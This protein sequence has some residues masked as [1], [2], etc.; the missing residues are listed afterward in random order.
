MT[1]CKSNFDYI[2]FNV[3]STIITIKKIDIVGYNITRTTT[4]NMGHTISKVSILI[5]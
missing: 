2:P 4:I 1:V 5:H 3:L